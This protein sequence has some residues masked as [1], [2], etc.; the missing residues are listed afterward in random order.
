MRI[1]MQTNLGAFAGPRPRNRDHEPA[2]Y[3]FQ[4]RPKKGR[5][6]YRCSSA[7]RI[8][9]GELEVVQQLGEHEL[10]AK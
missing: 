10:I 9:P 4:R 6:E 5:R 2:P 8:R 7:T 3:F 1:D